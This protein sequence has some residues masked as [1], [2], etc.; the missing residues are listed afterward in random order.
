MGTWGSGVAVRIMV[1]GATGMLGHK[2]F[3]G[4]RKSF[5]DTWATIRGS[6]SDLDCLGAS[7]Y[8]PPANVVEHVDVVDWPA[9][10]AVLQNFRPTV[11]VN[12]VGII[13][14]R[15]AANAAIPSLTINS[16]LPHRLAGALEGWQGRLVHISTDCVFSGRR[17]NYTEEDPSDAEDLYGRTKFL[18]EVASG[19]VITLRTSIIG[20][21]LREHR[22]LLDWLLRQNG[23]TIQGYR[24]AFYSGVTTIELTN[25]IGDVIASHPT[26]TGVY[27]VTSQTISKYDLL[28]SIVE[29]F[30]LDIRVEPENEFFCDRSLSGDRFHAATGYRCPQWPTLIQA[31]L[32]DPTSYDDRMTS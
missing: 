27:Q 11:V 14:Q 16:L 13:K 1:L 22:S 10:E 23:R 20:R 30:G 8:A 17:G 7:L 6:R 4:L 12:C 15:A 29:I 28:R 26:L 21:E 24:R 9:V 31:L 5:P 32:A 2:V 19:N 3:Q 25:V 18:G